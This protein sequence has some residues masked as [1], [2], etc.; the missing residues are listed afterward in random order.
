MEEKQN[1]KEELRVCGNCQAW[2]VWTDL[3]GHWCYC[4]ET[5]KI[6]HW[7]DP[8]CPY[9]IKQFKSKNNG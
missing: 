6:H 5:N 4:Q 2:N 3:E 9:Y 7:G 1:P 8:A